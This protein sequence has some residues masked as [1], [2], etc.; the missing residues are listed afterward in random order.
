MLLSCARI[1]FVISLYLLQTPITVNKLFQYCKLQGII[2]AGKMSTT[3]K[4]A[5]FFFG[6]QYCWQ[7]MLQIKDHLHFSY[8][9]EWI[10]ILLISISYVIYIFHFYLVLFNN[11]NHN[12]TSSHHN[13]LTAQRNYP[14][15][16]P[17]F[18][19]SRISKEMLATRRVRG[20]VIFV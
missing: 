6:N 17:R 10:I 11:T 9:N 12:K 19:T 1:R 8:I 4:F 13:H 2:Y 16:I 14:T 5:W 20:L 3:F 15:H 7:R 18:I